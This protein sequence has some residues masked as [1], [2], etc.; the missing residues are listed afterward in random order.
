MAATDRRVRARGA[1]VHRQPVRHGA[2]ADPAAGR[3]RGPG[4]G[5]VSEGVPRVGAVPARHEPEGVAVHDPSQHVPQHAA[6][7]R[8]EPDRRRQRDRRAG[9]GSTRGEDRTPEQLLTRATLDA[10]LQAALDALPEAFRQAVWLRDVEELSYAEI[11][12]MLDVPI[13][14]VMSRISRG[15]RMLYDRLAAASRAAARA[16]PAERRRAQACRMSGQ[17]PGECRTSNRCWP[18]TSMARRGRRAR[19]PSKRTCGPCPPCRD[20]VA[21]ERRRARCVARADR[22]SVPARPT[23]PGA[24][25]GAEQPRRQARIVAA[26][27]AAARRVGAALAGRDA[28]ARR[29]RRLPVRPRE[30]RRGARRAA[31][32]SITS[33]ASSSRPT[34]RRTPDADALGRE[35]A[36]GPGLGA[37]GCRR[38][39]PREQLELLGV[40]RC[41]VERD[42]S[43]TCCTSGAASP[44]RSSC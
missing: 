21:G 7:R 24:L 10:D 36:A 25:R 8:P 11:A 40:R 6:A 1:V 35:W 39:P 19:A 22:G 28:R 43:R 44:C 13:G 31:H 27:V 12:R 16:A 2:A 17:R 14:T 33:C 34:A 32:R 20:R 42:A 4:P 37:A 15:R 9:G 38:A 29:R 30:Q 3:C 23:P 26:A 5:H 18:P 41:F